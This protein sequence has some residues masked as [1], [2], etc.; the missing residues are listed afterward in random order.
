[1]GL[2]S[3]GSD[4]LI[5]AFLCRVCIS[6]LFLRSFFFAFSFFTFS[7]CFFVIFCYLLFS[8]FFFAFRTFLRFFFFV[9]R[10]LS[11]FCTFPG[12]CCRLSL[13]LRPRKKK[14]QKPAKKGISLRPRLHQPR[15]K[16]S[17]R[18]SFSRLRP[19]DPS[20]GLTNDTREDPITE[21]SRPITKKGP[22]KYFDVMLPLRITN[23]I[24]WE[25]FGGCNV[26]KSMVNAAI[27]RAGASIWRP[28]ASASVASF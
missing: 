26:K 3:V 6:L 24:I 13:S 12:S 16:L 4:F 11:V 27:C 2:V 9:S 1:M 14:L 10:D 21:S 19:N 8:S 5:V 17:E 18:C 15:Q 20:S 25:L 22:K 7:F 28:L 23:Y